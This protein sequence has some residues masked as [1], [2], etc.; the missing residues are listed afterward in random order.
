VS[1]SS[2][3]ARISP[4]GPQQNTAVPAGAAHR[5]AA[6]S[7]RPVTSRGYTKTRSGP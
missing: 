5:Y 6:R 7:G 3:T 4:S 2:S 1:I